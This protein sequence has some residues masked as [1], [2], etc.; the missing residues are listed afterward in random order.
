MKKLLIYLLCSIFFCL[1][2]SR[3]HAIVAAAQTVSAHNE[4]YTA[5]AIPLQGITIDGKLDDWPENMNR[6]PLLNSGKG[7]G[8]AARG[9]NTAEFMIGY[10]GQ[11]NFLF[12]AV[13]VWDDDLVVGD[14][15]GTNDAC[16]IFVDGDNSGERVTTRRLSADECAAVQYVMC[17]PGGTYGPM[18]NTVNSSSN[19]VLS[20][21]DIT[22][23]RTRAAFSREG[24]TTIYE[25]AV[26]VFDHYPDSSTRLTPGKTIG[27]DVM[28]PDQDKQSRGYAFLIWAPI[29]DGHKFFN[30]DLLG[31]AVL[32]ESRDNMAAVRGCV[33]DSETGTPMQGVPVTISDTMGLLY[34]TVKTDE[35]GIYFITIPSEGKFAVSA[36]HVRGVDPVQVTLRF[37]HE[38]TVDF[39]PE[40]WW[41]Q[42][43]AAFF[44]MVKS[45]N[46]FFRDTM[47]N[48]THF[49]HLHVESAVPTAIGYLKDDDPLV[50]TTAVKIL[51]HLGQ[52]TPIAKSHLF[53]ILKDTHTSNK[54][55]TLIAG[56][57]GRIGLTSHDLPAVI[58]IINNPDSEISFSGY[59]LLYYLASESETIIPLL[60]ERFRKTDNPATTR[61]GSA[62]T[63][64][65]LGVTRDTLLFII[66]MTHEKN[67][68]EKYYGIPLYL[69]AVYLLG[70]L[71]EA[72]GDAVPRLLEMLDEEHGHLYERTPIIEAQ[73]TLI[74]ETLGKIGLKSNAA[75]TALRE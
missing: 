42:D 5:Y 62:Y 53:D 30:A 21:G 17:P 8:N 70:D 28:I 74:I 56:V 61:L 24:E 36:T 22:K 32:L 75:I 59:S 73:R 37:G 23:T 49:G 43:I 64:A 13:R 31:D 52:N 25:W 72:A 44:D 15:Y 54:L 41:N 26:E 35:N 71:G 27:F 9:N 65:K 6:Y 66:S 2:C 40:S 16:E 39:H 34:G 60:E 58:E 63:L 55:R 33:T 48:V 45:D 18:T 51:K 46:R 10:D 68:P 12:I 67:R 7:Y 1:P 29:K 19:L 47:V 38:T 20:F 11:S 4:D 3:V 69:C 50:Q 14:T 57:F